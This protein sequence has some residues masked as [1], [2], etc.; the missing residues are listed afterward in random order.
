MKCGFCKIWLPIIIVL[1]IGVYVAYQFVPASVLKE[2]HIT[3]SGKVGDSSKE[4]GGTQV[5]EPQ[6]SDDIGIKADNNAPLKK[7]RKLLLFN[8]WKFQFKLLPN[9]T[10]C[11]VLL[12]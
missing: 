1:S 2:L 10:C 5:H 7:T 9:S 3:T 4:G 11:R 12:G 6:Q 8:N